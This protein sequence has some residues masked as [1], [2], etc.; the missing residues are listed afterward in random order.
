MDFEG[1]EY[2]DELNYLK[3]DLIKLVKMNPDDVRNH[4]KDIQINMDKRAAYFQKLNE[5]NNYQNETLHGYNDEENNNLFSEIIN[6]NNTASQ[7]NE[8][9]GYND[10][11]GSENIDN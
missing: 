11:D 8:K 7:N 1:N 4:L 10:S 9:N 6:Q 3:E 5:D 2:D